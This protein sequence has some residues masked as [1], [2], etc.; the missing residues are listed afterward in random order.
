V[1][2]EL[3]AP[4]ALPPKTLLPLD[5]M[6]GGPQRQ[7]GRRR[8]KKNLDLRGTRTLTPRWFSP[9]PVGM[10][11]ALGALHAPVLEQTGGMGVPWNSLLSN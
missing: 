7:S 4:A 5:K 1:S 11:T 10:P 8:E 2:V 9:L 3:H 6:L